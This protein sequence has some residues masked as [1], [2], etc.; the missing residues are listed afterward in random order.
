[1]VAL[2]DAD[3]G[4]CECDGSR[5]GGH[6]L[7]DDDTPL[8]DRRLQNREIIEATEAGAGER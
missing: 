5:K 2:H 6:V 4:A 1:V 8:S 7:G 3:M